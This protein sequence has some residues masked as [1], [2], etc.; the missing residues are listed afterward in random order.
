MLD[1]AALRRDTP[2]VQNLIHFNNAGASLMPQ[3]V[4]EAIQ[5]HLILES[6]IGGYEAAEAAQ[7]QTGRFHSS[8]AQLLNTSAGNIAGTASATD[9]YARA[10]SS[11]PFQAGDVI[12]TTD[13]DYVSNQL[14]FLSLKNRYGIKVVRAGD[15]AEGGV[16][17]ADMELKIRQLQ[18]RLVAVTHVPTNSGLVQPVAAI[19]EICRA[20]GLI[21]LVDACQSVGQLP[22][23]V[24]EINCDFLTATCRK[25]LRG[26]RGTGFLYVS[27]R[28]LEAGFAPI[29]VDMH[30]AVWQSA[31]RF[32][33]APTAKRFEDWEFPV[34]LL[35]GAAVAA[36][37]ALQ[38]G[39]AAIERRNSELRHYLRQKLAE[40]PSV[41]IL[42]EGKTLCNLITMEAVGTTATNLKKALSSV[43][44][45]TSVSPRGGALIDFTRKGVQEALRISPH[46]YNTTDEIDVF[47]DALKRLVPK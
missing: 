43:K 9:A 21:Y 44:I 22:V 15:C 45:N 3:P 25:F 41:R 35:I 38:I 37:Y 23:D 10:L 13:N 27:D 5:K 14:A 33:V 12:L 19:G 26:P 20:H 8:L 30:S 42:D 11:I 18:P 29:F 16:D 39:L 34:A 31:D 6:E 32:E 36:D 47:A 24:T 2:A 28:M 7:A 40:I 46:Y 4:L 1:I 17:V